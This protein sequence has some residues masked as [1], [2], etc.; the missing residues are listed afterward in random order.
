MIM[1]PS[2]GGAGGGFVV[3]PGNY[4]QQLEHEFRLKQ[5]RVTYAQVEANRRRI[6]RWL[7]DSQGTFAL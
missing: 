4:N 1:A 3:T 5:E 2:C 6:K 7:N